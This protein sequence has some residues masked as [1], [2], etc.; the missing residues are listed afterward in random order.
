MMRLWRVEVLQ[1]L[2]E[3]TTTFQCDDRS[4]FHILSFS[5]SSSKRDKISG[6]LF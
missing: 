3:E 2:L 4:A 5:F 1:R 6:R